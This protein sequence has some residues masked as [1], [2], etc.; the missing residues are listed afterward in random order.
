MRELSVFCDE[1]GEQDMS[2]GY[3]LLTLIEHDQSLPI[4][5]S[6]AEYEARL[7]A[8]GLPDVPFHMVDL[9]HGHGATRVWRPDLGGSSC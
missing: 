1:A 7:R 5:L 2:D 3:Y 4:E 8:D 9:L 6:I